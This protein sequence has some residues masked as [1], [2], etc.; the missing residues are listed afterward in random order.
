MNKTILYSKRSYSP[1]FI[2]KVYEIE[3][4]SFRGDYLWSRE[5]F[6]KVVDKHGMWVACSDGDPVGY[7]IAWRQRNRRCY[8]AG[9]AVSKKFRGQGI[10]AQLIKRAQNFYRR[11]DF[12][13]MWLDVDVNNAAQW[14]YYRMGFRITK[15]SK[16]HKF[17]SMSKEI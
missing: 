7:L 6:H 1:A 16:K 5:R 15:H 4:S 14:L 3:R 11:R 2:D 9:I 13:W 10:G 17:I 8:I 12:R